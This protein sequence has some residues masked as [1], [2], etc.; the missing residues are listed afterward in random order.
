MTSDYN[1]NNR[2]GIQ[3]NA[4]TV[5]RFIKK[6]YLNTYFFSVILSR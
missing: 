1:Y 6:S 3:I 4:Y 2:L 5:L